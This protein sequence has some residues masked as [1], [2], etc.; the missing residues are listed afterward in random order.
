MSSRPDGDPPGTRPPYPFGRHAKSGESTSSSRRGLGVRPSIILSPARRPPRRSREPRLGSGEA[1]RGEGGPRGRDSG[2]KATDARGALRLGPGGGGTPPG[3]RVVGSERARPKPH[4][5]PVSVDH[6]I[7]EGK[8]SNRTGP[9]PM[10]LEGAH[11]RLPPADG[12]RAEGGSS[13]RTWGSPRS[14][15]GA[16]VPPSTLAPSPRPLET[17]GPHVSR[18]GSASSG[19]SG[20]FYRA[21]GD[22]NSTFLLSEERS[23][24]EP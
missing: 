22:F 4:R 20:S 12:S 1:S 6:R 14:R 9:A 3:P 17:I 19:S 8:D 7:R 2:G 10:R 24:Q 21:Q 15:D 13:G 18:E 11:D 5:P 16:L 23:S